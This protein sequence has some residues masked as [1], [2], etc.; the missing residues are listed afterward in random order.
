MGQ[1]L[2]E[3][4]LFGVRVVIGLDAE[5]LLVRGT[6]SYRY[7]SLSRELCNACPSDFISSRAN[8]ERIICTN[9]ITPDKSVQGGEIPFS[10]RDLAS[11][12]G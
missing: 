3:E 9:K 8:L 5:S 1:G 10:K 4:S 11:P 2:T 12:L 6:V 7:V